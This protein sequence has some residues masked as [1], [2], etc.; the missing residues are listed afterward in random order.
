MGCKE[1]N[2]TKKIV[3]YRLRSLIWDYFVCISFSIA[4]WDF[5]YWLP[6]Q[7]VWTRYDPQK[8]LGLIRIETIWHSDGIILKKNQQTT[9]KHAK[10]SQ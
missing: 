5:V 10:I 7:T 2:Q 6:L 3:P 4:N 1:S 9:K 8:A